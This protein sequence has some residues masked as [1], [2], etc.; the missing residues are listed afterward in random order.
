MPPAGIIVAASDQ[1]VMLASLAALRRVEPGRIR[2]PQWVIAVQLPDPIG[3]DLTLTLRQMLARQ[4]RVASAEA[5]ALM[6]D[7]R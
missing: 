3:A 4:L 5:A 7:R 1:L 6:G 2:P